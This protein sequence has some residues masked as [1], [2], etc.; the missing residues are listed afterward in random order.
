MEEVKINT[1]YIKLDQFIKWAGITV[2]GSE[3]KQ[4]IKS[5]RVKVNGEVRFER[6]KKLRKGDIVEVDGKTYKLG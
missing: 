4:I 6:G 2:T 3:A 1:E 5:G